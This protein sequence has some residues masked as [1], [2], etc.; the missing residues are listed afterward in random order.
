MSTLAVLGL[1]VALVVLFLGTLLGEVVIL[2]AIG[3][4]LGGVSEQATVPYTVLAIAVGVCFQVV[5]VAIWLLLSM[6]RRGAIFSER[7]F[8]WVDV[9]IGAGIAATL[10]LLGIAVLIYLL[11]EPPLDAPGI[12][13]IALGFVVAS[14]AFVLLMVVMRGLLRSATNLQSEL[15]EVV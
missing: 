4:D 3:R 1:R 13:V 6:I 8:R 10:L 11:I 7:A 12:V 15:E 9:I 5:L 2:P 14:G